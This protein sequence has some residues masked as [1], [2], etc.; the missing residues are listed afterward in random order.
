MSPAETMICNFRGSVSQGLT[1]EIGETVQILEKCE[2]LR[3][4]ECLLKIQLK[5]SIEA[6]RVLNKEA[7]SQGDLP[8]KLYSLEEGNCNQS[9][10]GTQ[11][12]LWTKRE[13]NTTPSI[14]L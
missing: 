2:V 12:H 1:L 10:S 4:L 7:H 6:V 11:I 9:R 8:N 3:T 14:T 13:G 5:E